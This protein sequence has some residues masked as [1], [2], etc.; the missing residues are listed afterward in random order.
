MPSPLAFGA[1]ALISNPT[2][3]T[4]PTYGGT[5][6]G[7]VGAGELILNRV[8]RP[9]RGEEYGGT[10]V[11]WIH[12]RWN[13]GLEVTE[14]SWDQDALVASF[15]NFTGSQVDG[16]TTLDLGGGN[17]HGFNVEGVRLLYA[18]HRVTEEAGFVIQEALG[19]PRDLRLAW[20]RY[21]PRRHRLR[22]QTRRSDSGDATVTIGLLSRIWT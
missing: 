7:T 15:P 18:P 14:L 21:A 13:C 20:N 2:N 1:G 12:A 8:V 16:V 10:V 9:I 4:G 11:Q 19:V 6:L 5:V 17:G 22:F 3:T